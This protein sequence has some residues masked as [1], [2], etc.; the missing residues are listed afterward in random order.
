MVGVGG[1][2]WV[3]V[4]VVYVNGYNVAMVNAMVQDSDYTLDAT[5]FPL[6]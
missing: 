3:D 5:I 4:G 2:V 6:N 1:C